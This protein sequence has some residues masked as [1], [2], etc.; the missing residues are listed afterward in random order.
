[1]ETPIGD[2]EDSH[3][4]DFLEDSNIAQPDEAATADTD[5]VYVQQVKEYAAKEGSEVVIGSD[6][7]APLMTWDPQSTAEAETFLQTLGIAPVQFVRLRP[8]QESK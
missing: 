2:D 5:N 6:A 4:G 1:M 8:I 7:H 3:I